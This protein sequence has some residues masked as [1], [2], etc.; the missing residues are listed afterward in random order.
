[1]RWALPKGNVFSLALLSCCPCWCLRCQPWKGPI[2]QRWRMVSTPT[3]SIYGILLET[4]KR[5]GKRYGRFCFDT[6]FDMIGLYS[7][8]NYL[9]ALMNNQVSL[10]TQA[11]HCSWEARRGLGASMGVK[12]LTENSRVFNTFFFWQFPIYSLLLCSCVIV[13]IQDSI[14]FPSKLQRNVSGL[15]VIFKFF[16]KGGPEI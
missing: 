9:S 11:K 12:S 10:S 1:M 4:W 3:P 7:L 15:I 16:R 13:W 8:Q 5:S 2:I 14:P 6:I